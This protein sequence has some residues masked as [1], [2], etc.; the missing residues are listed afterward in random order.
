[1]PVFTDIDPATACLDLHHA[2]RVITS[3]TRAIVP[4]HSW[5]RPC[6]I[7]EIAALAKERGLIVLED[8]AQAQG[9]TLQGRPMGVWGAM[10]MFSYSKSGS[11]GGRSGMK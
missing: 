10:G 5:G 2:A 6:D 4:M 8:A 7:D 3:R 11:W 9:A 1:V